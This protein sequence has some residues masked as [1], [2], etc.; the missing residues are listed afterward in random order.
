MIA[1]KHVDLDCQFGCVD[2]KYSIDKLSLTEVLLIVNL[3]A[4]NANIP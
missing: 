3:A 4:L 2:C 1:L